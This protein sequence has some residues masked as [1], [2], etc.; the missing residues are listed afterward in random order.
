MSR[1][2]SSRKG[3]RLS[4]CIPKSL[5][6]DP[7]IPRPDV[8]VREKYYDMMYAYGRFY[9]STCF[10]HAIVHGHVVKAVDDRSLLLQGCF[11]L[12]YIPL[13]DSRKLRLPRPYSPFIPLPIF[14]PS[15]PTQ[16]TCKLS[17]TPQSFETFHVANDRRI[18]DHD[19]R[20][21]IQGNGKSVH[22]GGDL[23]KI[24]AAL[25]WDQSRVTRGSM[26]FR[27]QGKQLVRASG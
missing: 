4:R 15:N 16:H 24:R 22:D 8:R 9:N 7:A 11:E 10:V 19:Q 18:A 26:E 27:E 1:S 12:A 5:I 25:T 6:R 13:L 14:S 3:S 23:R 21:V 20:V 2:R 17:I